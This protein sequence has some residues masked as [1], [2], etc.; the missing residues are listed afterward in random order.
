MDSTLKYTYGYGVYNILIKNVILYKY[1]V[2]RV[3]YYISTKLPT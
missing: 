3:Y 2:F 1:Y